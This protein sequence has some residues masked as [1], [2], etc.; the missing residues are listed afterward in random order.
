MIERITVLVVAL[1]WT[2]N[3]G[4]ADDDK[5]NL[6][7]KLTVGDYFYDDYSGVDVN[8]RW[9]QHDTSAWVGAYHDR[10]FGTQ[11]R[12]GFDTS[13]N[14]SEHAQLQPS[15]Q[16]ATYGFVGGSINLQ[17]G[18]AWFGII[19]IG[20]TNLKPY[21]NLNFDP[22]DSITLGAGHRTESGGIYTIFVV[23]DDRLHTGQRDWHANARFPVGTSR[24]TLDV[25]RKSGLSDA[26]EI[27]AWGFSATWD[28]PTV[29][30]RLAYDPK[31]NFSAQDAWRVAAGMRF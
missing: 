23:A 21:F 11:T 8:L 26:G 22:N 29:F 19:G 31:Q 4:A 6:A 1:M 17:A 9:R 16:I 13:F 30:V 25:L 7:W 3:S 12:A 14:V 15:L 27:T 24:A 28:W 5:K 2:T 20:R 10:E 18:D